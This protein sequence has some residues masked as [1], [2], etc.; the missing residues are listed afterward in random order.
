VGE[1]AYYME[2]EGPFLNGFPEA[3]RAE[4]AAAK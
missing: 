1:S 2:S 4:I 3:V